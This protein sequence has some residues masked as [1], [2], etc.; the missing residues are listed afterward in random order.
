MAETT[1]AT[2]VPRFF[3][4]TVTYADIPPPLDSAVEGAEAE[5]GEGGVE[6]EAPPS[7]GDALRAPV[8]LSS[9]HPPPEDGR[10]EEDDEDD[11]DDYNV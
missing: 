10:Q 3:P 5:G 7:F 6:G 9:A 2:F 4:G 8:L 11:D 1:P